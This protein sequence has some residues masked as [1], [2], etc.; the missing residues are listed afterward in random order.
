MEGALAASAPI[1]Q[2]NTDCGDFSAVIT[3]AFKKADPLCPHIIRSSWDLINKMGESQDGLN[4]LSNIFHLCSPLT[5]SD[6]LKAY[7]N[8]IYGDV[9]MANYPYSANFL[10][11]LPAWPI[12]EMCN[13]MTKS[14]DKY[15]SKNPLKLLNA[16]YKGV[17]VYNNF[18][19]QLPCN[20]I[21]SDIPNIQMDSWDYQAKFFLSIYK[22]KIA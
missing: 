17:N 9:S 11:P 12:K 10:N 4:N 22:K 8:E 16:I 3:S 13:Q 15:F 14:I 2:C 6:D 18:T 21:D 5:N 1:F 20:N 19:G 7:L